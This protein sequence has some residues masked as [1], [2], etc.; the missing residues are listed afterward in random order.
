MYHLIINIYNGIFNDSF[1]L[2]NLNLQNYMKKNYNLYF[3]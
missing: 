3:Y 1:K 2:K